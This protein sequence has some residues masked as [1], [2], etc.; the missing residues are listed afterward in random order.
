MTKHLQSLPLIPTRIS[1]KKVRYSSIPLSLY[2]NPLLYCYILYSLFQ[3]SSIIS[4]IYYSSIPLSSIYIYY[5]ALGAPSPFPVSVQ[6]RDV[7]GEPKD[8]DAM[9]FHGFHGQALVGFNGETQGDIWIIYGLYIY[10]Y[11]YNVNPGLI[12]H[13]LLIGGVLLQYI[14]II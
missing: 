9:A 14:V 13:C 5:T 11:I 3:Y 1:Q 4:T 12:N 7:M 2:Y 10:N 8:H 6:C